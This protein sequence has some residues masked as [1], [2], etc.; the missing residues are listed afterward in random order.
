MV[1]PAFVE[2]MVSQLGFTASDAGYVAAAENIGK[3]V[4]SVIMMVLITKV[5]WRTLYYAALSVLIIGNG[6]CL[7]ID[8]PEHYRIIRFCTGLANG[9]I[10]PLSYVIVGLTARTERNFGFLMI[11]LMIY[12]AAVFYNLPTVFSYIGLNG[13]I[14]IFGAISVSDLPFVRNMPSKGDAPKF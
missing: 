1:Q 10:V 11:S 3:A 8:S 4:Q 13:L 7:F 9:T 14:I 6:I 12:G 5:N 2:G